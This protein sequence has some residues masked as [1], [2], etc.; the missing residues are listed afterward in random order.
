[1]S[2]KSDA[3]SRWL[4]RIC[5]AAFLVWMPLELLRGVIPAAS[6]Y[7]VIKDPAFANLATA[8][9]AVGTILAIVGTA[10]V[11]RMQ[12]HAAN[13]AEVRRRKEAQKVFALHVILMGGLCR[14]VELRFHAPFIDTDY[15]INEFPAGQLERGLTKLDT[16]LNAQT[17]DVFVHPIGE[18]FRALLSEVV[19]ASATVRA[20]HRAGA[21]VE[22]HTHALHNAIEVLIGWCDKMQPVM[23]SVLT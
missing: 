7:D 6:I 10:A 13:D 22:P 5:V 14:D 19:N 1:M 20:A 8:L 16:I 15:L 23:I 3:E 21:N 18:S 11:A 9:G 12:I 4:A 2:E 17:A